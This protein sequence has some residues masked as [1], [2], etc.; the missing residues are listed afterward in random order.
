MLPYASSDGIGRWRRGGLDPDAG[1]DDHRP[2]RS[3]DQGVA[4]ELDDL[5]VGLDHRADAQQHVLDRG[6]VA[7]RRAA[8]AV[9]QRER[10]QRA[11]HLPR[12][13]VG[14]G[15]DP[16]RHIADQLRRRPAGAAGEH[17]AEAVVVDDAD[18]QLDPRGRHRLNDQSVEPV[19]GARDG[20]FD[21]GGGGAHRLGPFESEPDA[22]GVGLVH[23]PGRARLERDR[24]AELGRGRDRLLGVATR[25]A[26]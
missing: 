2:V 18:D 8:V 21:L 19:S 12:F 16:D 22:A 9:E 1:V 11:H 13:E 20:V 14:H 23:E 24:P 3:G 10:A 5:G 4:V 25:R 6:Q 15:S 7:A 17:R 26:W